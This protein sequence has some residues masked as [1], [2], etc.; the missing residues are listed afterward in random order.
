MADIK[1]LLVFC[2]GPHDVAFTR[3][4]LE[5]FFG[6]R[7]RNWKFSEYPSP[8]NSLF[9]E[10]VRKH[11]ARDLSL[12]M[13]H[14]FFLP[15]RTLTTD[16]WLILLFNSGGKT[17]TEN[18]TTFLKSYLPLLKQSA[19]FPDD[20]ENIVVETKYLFLYDA[21]NMNPGEVFSMFDDQYRHIEGTDWS[22]DNLKT[23]LDRFYATTADKA[24][25]IWGDSTGK[26]TL[27]N[28]VFPMFENDN[29]Q[30]LKKAINGMDDWFDW[31]TANEDEKK[32]FA[33][34]AKRKK[35]I[36]T[37]S[38]QRKKPGGSFTVVLDQAKLIS[39]NTF[40]SDART[41]GFA[42]FLSDWAGLSRSHTPD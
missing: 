12:D 3:H 39:K 41:K 7:R 13:A 14:K 37:V 26:G 30:L 31:D 6:A 34:R 2:E 35:A 33:E 20:A 22:V 15:D 16:G 18:V 29:G 38:G 10:S 21:D 27:E 28:I 40:L 23:E 19:V 36:L 5:F 9:P 17:K 1:A 25:Y 32:S 8:F 11:A 42:E 4:V 24:V